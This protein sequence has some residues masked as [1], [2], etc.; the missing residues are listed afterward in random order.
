MIPPAEASADPLDL[1]TLDWDEGWSELFRPHAD[2]SLRPARVA[3]THDFVTPL[4]GTARL[5]LEEPH[6][7]G[8]FH[9]AADLGRQGLDERGVAAIELVGADPLQ[10]YCA[11]GTRRSSWS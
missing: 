2:E 9:A 4:F 1:Q 5:T 8:Q 11:P 6:R 7:V 3:V 10:V